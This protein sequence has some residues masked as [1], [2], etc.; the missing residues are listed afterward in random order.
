MRAPNS[1]HGIQHV[2]TFWTVP[3]FQFRSH[4]ISG[5]ALNTALLLYLSPVWCSTECR[6]DLFCMVAVLDSME[7]CWNSL[8]SMFEVLESLNWDFKVIGTR[9]GV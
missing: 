4:G 6:S 1:E 7:S 8:N 3:S 2:E 5:M 9:I